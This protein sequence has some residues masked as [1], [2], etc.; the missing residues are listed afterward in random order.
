MFTFCTV[1]NVIIIKY[2][3]DALLVRVHLQFHSKLLKQILMT[4]HGE[5][6]ICVVQLPNLISTISRHFHTPWQNFN[7]VYKLTNRNEDAYLNNAVKIKLSAMIILN[8][9]HLFN[10]ILLSPKNA[11]NGQQ[12]ICN[13][14]VKLH[15]QIFIS[16]T[17]LLHWQTVKTSLYKQ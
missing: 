5:R 9:L 3:K 16:F 13:F 14:E 12:N 15:I 6:S 2:I 11:L 1:H 8:K 17:S 7:N 10:I 4:K